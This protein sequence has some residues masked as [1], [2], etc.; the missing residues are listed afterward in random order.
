MR[1]IN[2]SDVFKFA[3]ILKKTRIKESIAK[4]YEDGA[5][6]EAEIK[7]KFLS[8]EDIKEQLQKAQNDFGV[9]FAF[10]ILDAAADGGVEKDLYDLLG[11]I[12]EK[13]PTDI[14]NQSLEKTLEDLKN[15]AKE[16]NLSLFFK[17]A[18]RLM[19]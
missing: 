2:T 14:E 6:K 13:A 1:K 18:S 9:Q 3:K 12:T 4:L 17:S 15:I 7:K 8:E 10:S 16:N 19:Q 11:G 5:A